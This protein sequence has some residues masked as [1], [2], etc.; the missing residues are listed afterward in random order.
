MPKKKKIEAAF[1]NLR[2]PIKIK[3]IGIVSLLILGALSGMIFFASA[4][5]SAHSEQSIQVSNL[6]IARAVADWTESELRYIQNETS[7]M[8]STLSRQAD[9]SFFEKNPEFI[10]LGL[11]RNG[12]GFFRQFYNRRL[13]QSEGLSNSDIQKLNRINKSAIQNTFIGRF[14]LFNASTQ[15]HLILGLCQKIS[16]GFLVLYMRPE[17]LLRGFE[18]QKTLKMFIVDEKGDVIL[19][20]DPL[21]IKAHSNLLK[22]EGIREMWQSAAIAG[23]LRY[24]SST[25]NLSYIASY[26][27]LSTANYA[28][29][30]QV[31]VDF[32]FEPVR[33]IR[34]R[35]LILM[36]IFLILAVVCLYFFAKL[37]SNPIIALVRAAQKVKEGNYD[38]DI[39]SRSRDEVGQLTYAF[40]DM[41]KGLGEREK[42]KDAFGKFVNKEIAEQVLRGDVKLGGERKKAAIFFSDLRGFTALS[43]GLDPEEVVEFLNAYFTD[44]VN[45]VLKTHGVVDKYIGDAIM[46]HWGAIGKRGKPTENA[47]NAALFMRKAL[48][49]FNEKHEGK[50][51]VAKMGSGINTGQVISGQIGS[52]QRLEYTVIG[53]A[54]NLASRIEALNKPFGTDLLISEDSYNEVNNIFEVVRMPS[55]KVKGKSQAQKIYAV[56]GRKDDPECPPNLDLL[57]KLLGI[58]IK[59]EATATDAEAK[60]EKFKIMEDEEK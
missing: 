24:R 32:V 12:E 21:L 60:E 5:F 45:C 19:H 58:E 56:L 35:N 29:V 31:S 36:A 23:Q 44:M 2:Y 28:L 52:E 11:S 27:K 30:A 42:I 53:D 34:N 25:D 39:E 17:R 6:N 18:V 50:F 51:P 10:Y 7:F 20:P 55:I 22:E 40:R 41:A 48:L 14:T 1:S 47:V 57:R 38:L 16:R 13:M 4:F 59:K 3:L 33:I 37:I 8:L 43:E 54:V 26:K 46:A 49:A 9:S 15:K